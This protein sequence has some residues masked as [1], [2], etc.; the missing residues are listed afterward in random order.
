MA[1]IDIEDEELRR[2][3]WQELN[4]L[5]HMGERFA[6]SHPRIAGRLQLE[7]AQSPD[8]HV[9]RLIESFAFLT[10]RVQR[11]ID[12][13][14]GD[15]AAELLNVLYPHYLNPIPSMTVVRFQPDPKAGKLTSGLEIARHSQIFARVEDGNVCRFRTCYPVTLW[16]IKLAYA[17]LEAP[18]RHQG[19][20]VLRLRFVSTGSTLDELG[21]GEHGFGRV[22]F[23]LQGVRGNQV[24]SHTLYEILM[25]NVEEVR[26]VPDSGSGSRGLPEGSIRP[27]GLEDDESVLPETRYGHPAYRLLQEYFTFREKFLF[28][29]FH[30]LDQHGSR[31]QFDLLIFFS[32]LPAALRSRVVDFRGNPTSTEEK[33]RLSL[34]AESFQ[35]GCTPAVNLFPKTT[36]PIRI[37]HRTSEYLLVP[38]VHRDKTTEIHSIQSVASSSDADD[39]SHRLEPFYSFHHRMEEGRREALWHA[40][41]VPTSRE[42]VEGTELLL[43]FRDREFKPTSPPSEIVFAH[44][45]CTNR[46]LAWEI[47][48]LHSMSTD[49]VAGIRDITVLSRPTP[50]VYPPRAGQTLWRLVSHLSLNYLSLSE[51]KKG[52]E[53]FQELA[54]LYSFYDTRSVGDQVSGIRDLR[55]RHVMGLAPRQHNWGGYCRGTEITLVFDE[56]KFDEGSSAFLLASVLNEF[57]S[58]YASV[59]SFTQLIIK[60]EQRTEDEVWK[61]WDPTAGVQPVL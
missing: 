49:N 57:F 55:Y 20:R 23:Y 52:L 34:T 22:R 32:S 59:N 58:L 43:S 56:S 27:V 42:G 21:G 37:D 7:P 60:S 15:V 18:E 19:A 17:G 9:E 38:D 4:Y 40:R 35:L 1:T 30:H 10:G 47:P 3:Y 31:R 8:P 39:R 44:T 26:I 24:L 13:A 54:Q 6:E 50:Q 48:A 16:P 11:N 46:H 12:N 14:F 28:L 25:N 2:Y 53:A 45:L 61:R 41:R 36:E 5:R 33:Y 51:G 29:D